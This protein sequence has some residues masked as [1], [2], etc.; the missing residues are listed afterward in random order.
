MVN[1]EDRTFETN[2]EANK[3]NYD[4]LLPAALVDVFLDR[5]LGFY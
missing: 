1:D 2:N 4:N 5:K 3:N